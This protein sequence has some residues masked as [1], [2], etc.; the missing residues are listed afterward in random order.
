M[1]E[2]KRKLRSALSTYQ[3]AWKVQK[4]KTTKLEEENSK[5]KKENGKLKQDKEK[6]SEELEKIKREQDTYKVYG[7]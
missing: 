4:M 2:E 6:L 7:I 5:L 3:R 1:D